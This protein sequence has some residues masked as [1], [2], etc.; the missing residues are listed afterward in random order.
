[1]RGRSWADSMSDRAKAGGS[2]SSKM[3][4]SAAALSTSPWS[5]AT[6]E[7]KQVGIG[8]LGVDGYGLLQVGGGAVEV[9]GSGR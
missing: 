6:M 3:A 4:S 8:V 9:A 2:E 5:R 1:M 7:R